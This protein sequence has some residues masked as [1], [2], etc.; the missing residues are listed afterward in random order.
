MNTDLI[1][2]APDQ[3]PVILN[4]TAQMEAAIKRI[5]TAVLAEAPM[6]DTAKGRDAVKALAAN[7]ART[8][9][10]LRDAAKSLK[11][12]AQATINKINGSLKL[13]ETRM[14]ALRDTVRAPLTK[15]EDAEKL[16][17]NGILAKIS[18]IGAIQAAKSSEA[19]NAQMDELSAREITKA[20][21]QEYLTEAEIATSNTLA[22]L[23]I[24]KDAAA[25]DE[26]AR[27]LA[28][29]Q[30]IELEEL[31]AKQKEIEEAHAKERA[32]QEA[33]ATAE[34]EGRELA[35]ANL[36][37]KALAKQ[38]ELEAKLAASE[39]ARK[40]AQEAMKPTP[41]EPHTE[42]PD[43]RPEARDGATGAKPETPSRP[44]SGT[45]ATLALVAAGADH[46]TAN[47]IMI[48]IIAGDVPGVTF[49]A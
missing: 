4:D 49:Q 38:A 13:F 45:L 6:M 43:A 11:E 22:R 29:A 18:A 39:K 23:L 47:K 8:K 15:Y 40:Y 44:S 16:R 20:D 21:Y 19:I 26:E 42:Q 24:A 36:R 10:P 3:R 34:R 14:D 17:K 7:V 48:A 33:K 37:A 12:D 9:S 46:K 32:E 2:I 28:E 25:A 5:E 35:E 30:R 31:R 27:R 41:E 1:A